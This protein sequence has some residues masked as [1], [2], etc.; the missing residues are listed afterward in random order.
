MNKKLGL[1]S[2]ISTGVGLIVATSCIM[3]LGM[4]A[5]A[6][7]IGFLVAMLI[8]AL[9][10]MFTALSISELNALLPNVT[11]GLAQYTLA[12]MGPFV[13]LVSMAGGYLVCNLLCGTV[14]MAMFGNVMISILPYD[15][16]SSVYS[17]VMLV[18]LLIANLNGVDMFAKIQTFVAYSLIALMAVMGIIGAFKLGTGTVV[19]Q[20]MVTTTNVS[21]IF[22]MVGLAFF[23]FLGCEFIIP[24]AK[25]VKNERRNVPLGMVLSIVIVFIMDAI[26]M[27][28]IG[29]YVGWEELGSSVSPHLLYGAAL[30]G[31]TG[32]ILMAVVSILAV[33]STVNS[34]IN[35]LAYITFGMAKIGLLP[36]VFYKTNK[37]GAPLAGL[38]L[39]GGLMLILNITGLSTTDELSFLILI[40]CVFWM[41]A[42]MI[43][44]INVLILRAKLPKAPRTF[45]VP[46]GPIIPIL[47]II[48]N[49]FMIINIDGDPAVRMTIYMIA[50]A[51]FAILAILAIIWIKCFMK[52]PLFKAYE[53]K[54]VMAME[55]DLYHMTRKTSKEAEASK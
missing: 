24:I 27:I 55:N 35:G 40:G 28:G 2:V 6:L 3:S 37:K 42:Y 13:S 50:G 9:I 15:I 31:D 11:G 38:L 26:V 29:F 53:I 34:V 43:S 18:V 46:F 30:L 32:L 10:N 36:A 14:E 25:D 54:E 1:S 39:F 23:M 47:G 48:G 44:N 17:A 52:R 22:S 7:G 8:A 4:G 12:G 49:A 20:E 21:D 33:L 19:V 41:V 51:I 16:S 5:G 45:R